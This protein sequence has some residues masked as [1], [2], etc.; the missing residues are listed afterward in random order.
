[1]LDLGAIAREPAFVIGMAAALVAVKTTIIFGLGMLLRMGWRSALA[2]GLLLSQGG[3]FGFVLFTQALAGGIIDAETNSLFGAIVT[4]SMATTPFLMIATRRIRSGPKDARTR[5]GP[6]SDGATALIIGYGRFGQ[7]VGQMLTLAGLKISLIDRNVDQ[8]DTA[9]EFGARVHYGDGLRMDLLRQA[10]AAEASLLC[11]C[12]D[13]QQ[14]SGEFL[15]SVREAYPDAAIMVRAFDRRSVMALAPPR[16]DFLVREVRESAIAMARAALDKVEITETE[17]DD[18][19][20]RFR[21]NDRQRLSD[22]VA[23][24]DLHAGDDRIIRAGWQATN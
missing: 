16:Y 11:F 13:G 21:V 6:D 23:Q 15:A 12:I 19:E 1:M 20:D 14:L 17:I 8:I 3:E 10:G 22:Q 9:D 2:L 4:L 7:T 24:N 5:K 18:L